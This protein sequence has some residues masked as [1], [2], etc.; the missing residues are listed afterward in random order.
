MLLS[1]QDVRKKFGSILAVD[2]VTLAVEPGEIRGVVGPNGAGKTTLFNL[3]TGFLPVS[4]GTIMFDGQNIT[5]RPTHDRVRRGMARTFQTPQ[6]FSDMTILDNILVSFYGSLL[7]NMFSQRAL[8]AAA[9]ERAV[10]ILELVGLADVAEARASELPY[11]SKRKLEIARA[12]MTDPRIVLLD[13]PAAGMNPTEVEA[14]MRL[15]R[16]I[17][18]QNRGVVVVEHNMRLIMEISDQVSVI[19]FGRV[20]AEGTPNDVRRDAR[21]I[22]AYLGEHG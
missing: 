4:S 12:L 17:R 3:I 22:S 14:L 2:G 5:R 7:R 10:E 11:A 13:E 19:D 20:I 1:V 6:L 21:V 9:Q 16:A 15:I 8:R 18:T